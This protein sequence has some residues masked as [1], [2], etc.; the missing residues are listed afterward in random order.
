MGGPVNL[1]ARIASHAGPG[2]LL[3]DEGVVGALEE[4]DSSVDAI[5]GVSLA[6]IAEPV[7]LWAV[8]LAATRA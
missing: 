7:P 3:V 5:G 6:G 8:V 1:A 4:R 2:K